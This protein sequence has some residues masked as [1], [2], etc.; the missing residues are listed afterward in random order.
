ML[1]D[2]L[3]GTIGKLLQIVFLLGGVLF[4]FGGL[5]GGSGV[6]IAIGILLLC[7]SFGAR[8]ALGNIFRM[9]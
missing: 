1:K 3:A 4:L 6:S 7:M 5:F 8:Y 2:F 9:R